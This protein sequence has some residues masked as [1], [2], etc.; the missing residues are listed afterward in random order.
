MIGLIFI[1]ITPITIPRR[2]NA[3]WL[4]LSESN[5]FFFGGSYIGTKRRCCGSSNSCVG[6]HTSRG[7]SLSW[8]GAL[9][10]GG[11]LLFDRNG[12]FSIFT[13]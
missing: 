12:R 13:L 11:S 5:T 1:I 7:S 2:T 3:I 4:S 9:L 8:S 10:D 6:V